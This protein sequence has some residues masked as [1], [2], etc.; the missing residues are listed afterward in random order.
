MGTC[1]SLLPKSILKNGAKSHTRG[2]KSASHNM[3]AG[4]K[5]VVR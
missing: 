5:V 3:Q 2:S 4:R 1:A